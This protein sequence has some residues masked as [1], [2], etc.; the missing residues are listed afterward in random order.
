MD[1]NKDIQ[2]QDKDFQSEEN[3]SF[4]MFELDIVDRPHLQ[5]DQ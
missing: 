1:V 5:H 3:E 2:N 4:E